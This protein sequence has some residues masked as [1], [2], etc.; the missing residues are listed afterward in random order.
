MPIK[1]QIQSDI[2]FSWEDYQ[3]F[4]EVVGSLSIDQFDNDQEAYREVIQSIFTT[5]YTTDYGSN[6]NDPE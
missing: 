3:H 2:T 1:H 4:A 6:D 5:F